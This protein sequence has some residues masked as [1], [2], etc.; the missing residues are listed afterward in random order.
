VISFNQ[1]AFATMPPIKGGIVH[2]L[3]QL[4]W[5]ASGM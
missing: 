5:K 3:R 4:I 1:P 2:F